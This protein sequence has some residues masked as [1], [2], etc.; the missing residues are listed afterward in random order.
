MSGR[1]DAYAPQVGDRALDI[2]RYDLDLDYR[3]ATNR[4]VGT[5]E[6]RGRVREDARTI[7]L[8]LTGLRANDVHLEG[9][10]RTRFSQRERK[11]VITPGTALAAGDEFVLTIDYAGSPRPRRSPWGT[12]GWEELE[13][14]AIVASQPIGA[15]T[16][17]PCNDIP[18][19]KATYRIRITTEQ[20][21]DVVAGD[22][23]RTA[24]RGGRRTWEFVHE[25]PAATYLVTVLIG[26]ARRAVLDLDGVPGEIH[27]PPLLSARAHAD[28]EPLP[29]MMAA[30][31][32]A[33][34]PYPLPAYRVVVT[35]D[36]LE[37][38][39]EAQGTG[40]FGSNHIDGRGSLERLIAHEL[41]HQWFG[42]SVG[43]ARWRDIWLNEGAACY[44][45]WI[46]SEASGGHTAH[47]KAIAHHAKLAKAPQDL[48]TDDPGADQMFDDRLYKRGA[49]TLH[50]VRLTVGDDA[51]FGALRAW[52]AENRGRAVES[53][54]FVRFFSA[55]TG[56]DL[57][58][59][60][61]AW[62]GRDDLPDLPEGPDVAAAPVTEAIDVRRTR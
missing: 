44:A 20:V 43:V 33:F 5:A 40:I 47:A 30:F 53:D 8:D 4:L 7:A 9:E 61:E 26:R 10:R 23:V 55:H 50:A 21:Y 25:L 58:D 59:L 11:L 32:R 42:N 57:G 19:D 18:S 22:L 28:L 1:G 34:G 12:L 16:W 13:D 60:F 37:I 39:L 31:Q 46:W 49:L 14:G 36:E 15:S 2:D 45:E 29:R 41:A 51:F 38:P 24:V 35:D 17:F 3:V 62:I 52:T 56:R 48:R 6:I 54:A 27:Y